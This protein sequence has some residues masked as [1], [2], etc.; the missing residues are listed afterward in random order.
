MKN[1]DDDREDIDTEYSG[2]PPKQIGDIKNKSKHAKSNTDGNR[3]RVS[4]LQKVLELTDEDIPDSTKASL[5]TLFKIWKERVCPG[6]LDHRV[7]VA[8]GLQ[9]FDKPHLVAAVIN[10][11]WKEK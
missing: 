10:G 8:E 5:L 1:N 9:K 7:V 4:D 11:R 6:L 2:V 3:Q